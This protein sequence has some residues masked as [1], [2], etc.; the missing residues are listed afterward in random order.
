MCTRLSFIHKSDLVGR[1]MNI[2]TDACWTDRTALVRN[3]FQ[4][5][6][7]NRNCSFKC[8]QS[9]RIVRWDSLE[10]RD[11][12]EY[13]TTTRHCDSMRV[14]YTGRSHR[15]VE[16][17]RCWLDGAHCETSTDLS[18]ERIISVAKIKHASWDYSVKWLDGRHHRR[19]IDHLDNGIDGMISDRRLCCAWKQTN[20]PIDLSIPWMRDLPGWPC[21]RTGKSVEL[22]HRWD[23]MTL[24]WSLIVLPTDERSFFSEWPFSTHGSTLFG[25]LTCPVPANDNLIC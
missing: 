15:T 13:S 22:V 23:N 5:L 25:H 14:P 17:R 3:E 9:E 2:T 7:Q 12:D 4:W 1:T 24:L 20:K 8:K 11:I 16:T 10:P 21:H 6:Q 18:E 19:T